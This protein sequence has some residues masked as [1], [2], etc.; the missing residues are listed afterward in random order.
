MTGP[1]SMG[2]GCD[3]A[4]V[5]F[6]AAHDQPEECPKRIEY[7]AKAVIELSDNVTDRDGLS[8]QAEI[9]VD[10]A[11]SILNPRWLETPFD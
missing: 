2:V 11:R 7:L 5:C 10:I 9:A 3:E 6:A 4:G 8:D 1:C